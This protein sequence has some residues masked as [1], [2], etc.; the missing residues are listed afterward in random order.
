M[1]KALGGGRRAFL[2][3][4]AGAAVGLPLLEVMRGKAQGAGENVLQN[5]VTVFTHGGTV[6]PR[7][8][9]GRAI[10]PG[11]HIGLDLWS[12][13]AGQSLG[14]LQAPLATAGLAP[15]TLLLRGVDNMSVN[16]QAPYGGGG[17]YW[18]NQ[19][20]LTCETL[21]GIV[22]GDAKGA[23]PVGPSFDSVLAA[24]LQSTAPVHLFVP[25]TN[26]SGIQYGTPFYS[27]ARR[28]S[29]GNASPSKAF[30]QLFAT[31][32]DSSGG[33]VSTGPDPALV[34]ANRIR[35]SVL[36]GTMEGFNVLRAR[37]SLRDRK[38]LDAHFDQ[39]RALEL[40]V[41][42]FEA[43]QGETQMV[44]ACNKSAVQQSGTGTSDPRSDLI[45]TLHAKIIAGA[46]RC[47]VTRVANLEITNLL[48]DWL[49]GYASCGAVEGHNLGHFARDCGPSGAL[50][51]SGAKWTE[52]S[53]ANKQWH[54][55]IVA[56]I[57]KSLEEADILDETVILYTS[58]FSDSSQHSASDLPVL[59]VGGGNHFKLGRDVNF[60]TK[61]GGE[62]AT[63]AS[64]H[65]LFTSLF[66]AF[67]QPDTHFGNNLLASKGPLSGL[68]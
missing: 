44:A 60:N 58:E 49:P 28:P 27:A 52:E 34:K 10:K 23:G 61:T 36:N 1:R 35:Q 66:Q 15:K 33:T 65:N 22:D 39:L 18:S 41:E 51:S 50:K 40:E 54:M 26:K 4:A 38:I 68:T 42:A 21:Q 31:V 13:A 46:I 20:A 5:F 12:P 25:A 11:D 47:G 2:R 56:E 48:T 37:A 16:R 57:A 19:T 24:R 55:S 43:A 14:V 3:N 32:S 59:L 29:A 6:I 53:K 8:R 7:E 9:G 62:Y 17:H 45:G 63:T 67:G 30:D 64:M